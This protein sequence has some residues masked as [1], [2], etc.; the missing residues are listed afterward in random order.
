MKITK[1]QLRRIIREAVATGRPYAADIAEDFLANYPEISSVDMYYEYDADNQITD[2]ARAYGA[3]P[4]DV[5][6]FVMDKL[7]ALE[8]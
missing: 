6:S 5:K 8:T 1:R 7:E 3:D 4:E 2:Y